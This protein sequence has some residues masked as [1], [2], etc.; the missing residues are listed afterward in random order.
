MNRLR[1][2]KAIHRFQQSKH[3][4]IFLMLFTAASFLIGQQLNDM[5]IF[6]SSGAVVTV[7]GIF[8]MVKFT[9]IKEYRHIHDSPDEVFEE[10]SELKEKRLKS[11]IENEIRGI[12]MSV[13]GT[14][15]WAYGSYIPIL[16]GA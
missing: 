2:Y 1:L 3:A 7:S 16:V 13:L 15:I 9:S 14:I 10:T 5:T 11:E 4:P 6:S 8:F 12:V